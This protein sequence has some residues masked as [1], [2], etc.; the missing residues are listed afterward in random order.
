M[1]NL[2]AYAKRY[3]EVGFKPFPIRPNDK[4]PATE[5]GFKDA[6]SN[7]A[8]AEKMFRNHR[9]NIA[10]TFD[11]TVFVLDVDLKHGDGYAALEQLENSLGKL[12]ATLTAKTPSGG[13][14][15]Y[16]RKSAADYVVNGSNVLAANID[17]RT[18]KGYALVEPSTIEGKA[19]SFQDDD[20]LAGELTA[21]APMPRPWLDALANWKKPT[22]QTTGQENGTLSEGGRNDSLTRLAGAMRRHGM[23]LGSIHAALT[24]HNSTKCNPPL[25]AS[26][27]QSI[28]NSVARYAPEIFHAPEKPVQ[29][30]AMP[31]PVSGAE[32]LSARATPD[33]LVDSLFYADVALLV[34]AG[35]IGKTTLILYKGIHIV[36]GRALFG[37]R[38]HKPGTVLVIT[39][40]DSREMLVA[41]LRAIASAMSLTEAEKKV[42]MENFRISDL[43]GNGFRLTE[44]EHD[45]VKPSSGCDL[46]IEVC[47]TL[48]PV[49]IVIDPAVSFGV[50]ESRVNDAEQGLIEA[51]RRLRRALN[52]CV[53][54]IHHSGKANGREKTVDQYSGRGGSAFADGARMVHVLVN[55]TPAEWLDATGTDLLPGESGLL[56]ARPKMSY[57]APVGDILIKRTGYKFE[58]VQRVVNSKQTMLDGA[59]N[60]VWQ[61]LNF[62][63]GQGRYHT[64]NTLE[65]LDIGLKRGVIRAAVGWLHGA[66]RVEYRNMPNATKGGKRQYLHPTT[67]PIDNGA[68]IEFIPKN[69]GNH[70]DENSSFWC[71]P[72]IGNSPVAHQRLQDEPLISYGTPN[73]D[74][75]PM[76]HPAHQSIGHVVV[77]L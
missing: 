50:G 56:L 62:E 67:A 71:A 28:A 2:S 19:Y 21:I 20:I 70:A 3:A 40:E 47:Q 15:R 36:L 59:A 45:V 65:L 35:G 58:H 26:E 31:E 22:P 63:L 75:A 18:S 61:L 54:Y 42:V 73:N 37:L 66:Q 53:L 55:L 4:K 17:F 52:C 8:D 11:D 49:L 9:G 69:E 23:D 64:Q 27:I 29:T 13:E 16:F 43:S 60:Q 76:A 5:N 68:P 41:R 57:C 72:P 34:A 7:P 48:R 10:V 32:W 39:A 46:I 25:P 24:D 77:E 44:V 38:I 14:H 51:A 6:V 74:G 1:N 12:P 33:C 30:F